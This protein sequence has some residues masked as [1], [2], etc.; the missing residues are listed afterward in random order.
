MQNAITFITHYKN[1][2]RYSC[3]INRIIKPFFNKIK[4][5]IGSRKQKHI[6]KNKCVF[7]MY[8]QLPICTHSLILLL[9]TQHHPHAHLKVCSLFAIIQIQTLSDIMLKFFIHIGFNL[10]WGI[11][12]SNYLRHIKIHSRYFT[13]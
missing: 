7:L 3:R 13:L 9:L 6:D 12:Y 8:S 5:N 10:L 1:N 4:Q 2:N 11:I